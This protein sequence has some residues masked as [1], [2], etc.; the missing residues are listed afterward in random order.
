MIFHQAV[1]A[2]FTVIPSSF[3]FSKSPATPKILSFISN[4]NSGKIILTWMITDNQD[5]DRFELEKSLDGKSFKTAAL[6]FANYKSGTDSYQ[7]IDKENKSNTYYYRIR[8]IS[9]NG[10]V[11][12]SQ[13][14]MAGP[15]IIK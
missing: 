6:V 4:S 12:Y 5:V 3:N 11:D 8:I 10:S 14:I 2:S 9:K 13:A 15:D 7:F 1:S